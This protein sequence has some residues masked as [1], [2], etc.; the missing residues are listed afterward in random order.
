MAGGPDGKARST[1]DMIF[2]KKRAAHPTTLELINSSSSSISSIFLLHLSNHLVACTCL[3]LCK[4][5]FS[6]ELLIVQW[7]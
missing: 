4:D 7:K 5:N 1:N 3:G 6:L 2:C